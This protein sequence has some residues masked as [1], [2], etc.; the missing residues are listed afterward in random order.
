MFVA[1]STVSQAE[2]A[3]TFNVSETTVSKH[4][5]AESWEAE[6]T[7]LAERAKSRA[8]EAIVKSRAQRI[9][10][11]INLIDKVRDQLLDQVEKGELEI[12]LSELA[13]LLKVEALL[14][15]DATERIDVAELQ[16]SL[17][18]VVAVF[19]PFVPETDRAKALEQ[20]EQLGEAA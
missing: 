18:A 13:P 15:G 1:D 19:L 6:R 5:K 20:F 17:R 9:A 7:A 3:R 14:E 4:A 12:R 10:N 8:D 16:A 2:V 11:S